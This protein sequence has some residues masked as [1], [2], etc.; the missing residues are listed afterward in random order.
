MPR[1][2]GFRVSN[3]VLVGAHHEDGSQREGECESSTEQKDGVG[4]AAL[5]DG[6]FSIEMDV[7]GINGIRQGPAGRF[8]RHHA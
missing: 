7:L 8:V 1:N 2:L 3:V 6:G 5:L 4:A